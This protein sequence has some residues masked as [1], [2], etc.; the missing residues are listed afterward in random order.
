[1][2]KVYDDLIIINL[3]QT[4]SVL[5]F[6]NIKLYTRAVY[7]MAYDMDGTFMVDT[8]EYKLYLGS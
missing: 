8:F 7:N 4:S 2:K 1:M 3:Y 6:L 5:V